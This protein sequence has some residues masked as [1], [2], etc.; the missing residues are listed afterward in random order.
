VPVLSH[1]SSAGMLEPG[2]LERPALSGASVPRLGLS[3]VEW[4]LPSSLSGCDGE[5]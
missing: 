4:G 2:V 3:E 5:T 1:V